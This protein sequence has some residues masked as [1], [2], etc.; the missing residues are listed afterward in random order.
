MDRQAARDHALQDVLPRRDCQYAVG[1]V[2]LEPDHLFA[3]AALLDRAENRTAALD[4]KMVILRPPRWRGH[5]FEVE[6]QS[7]LAG[8]DPGQLGQLLRIPR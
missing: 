3:A 8:R 2:N 4:G 5:D 7:D 1:R 6:R